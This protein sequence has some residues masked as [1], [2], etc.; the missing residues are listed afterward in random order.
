[1]SGINIE[2]ASL[3]ALLLLTD[4]SENGLQL[5]PQSTLQ[6]LLVNDKENGVCILAMHQPSFQIATW[7]HK[8]MGS[9]KTIYNAHKGTWD[10]TTNLCSLLV[11]PILVL[12]YC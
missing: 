10:G 5:L 9:L 8:I 12:I 2:I 6:P 11:G 1:M 3:V 4:F 7:Y